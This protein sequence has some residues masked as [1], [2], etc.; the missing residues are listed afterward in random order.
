M[1]TDRRTNS[2]TEWGLAIVLS[3]IVWQGAQSMNMIT[4]HLV[5][6][7]NT[8]HVGCMKSDFAG[9]NREIEENIYIYQ[10]TFL[11]DLTSSS[12]MYNYIPQKT[13]MNY[14]LTECIELRHTYGR[15][16]SWSINFDSSTCMKWSQKRLK[17]H[18][19]K[20]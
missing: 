14:L 8:V 13:M 15:V 4:N 11:F 19:A 16:F 9:D 7:Y 20:M 18:R 3:Q 12:R 2:G 17:L 10:I 1:L 5:F 6:L